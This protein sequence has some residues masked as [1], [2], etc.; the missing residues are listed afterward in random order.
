[1]VKISLKKSYQISISKVITKV[2]IT[3]ISLYVGNEMITQ[4][5]SIMNQT[6]GGFNTGFRLIGWTVGGYPAFNATHFHDDCAA[7]LGTYS[8]TQAGTTCI[9]EYTGA[10]ILAV[11]GVIGF[12]SV[13]LEFVHLKL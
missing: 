2:V 1:M 5:G 6:E 9:T 8:T 12:A 7:A 11:V 10:G 3:A 13:V 4:I